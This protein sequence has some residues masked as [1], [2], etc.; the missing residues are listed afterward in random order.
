MAFTFAIPFTFPCG[1]R[2]LAKRYLT[3]NAYTTIKDWIIHYNLKPGNYL[4][5][6][7]LTRALDMSQTPIR[8]AL[9]RLEQQ[10]FVQRHPKKGYIVRSLGLQEVEDIYDLRIAIEVLAAQQAAT[11][12]TKKEKAQLFALLKRAGTL[13]ATDDKCK[14]VE[15]ER[16]FHNSIIEA[17]ANRLLCDI[18]GGILDRIWMIQNFN[19]LTSNRLD[20]AHR[21]HLKIFE[22]LETVKSEEAGKLMK[23]HLSSAKQYIMSRMRDTDDVMSRLLTSFPES[24]RI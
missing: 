12:I 8:E 9:T 20:E 10:R 23:T 11:R 5:F 17:T 1:L 13:I 18:C 21:Q 24:S 4:R 3:D 15:L 7:E 6:E 2:A 14:S 19:I 22:A 16:G